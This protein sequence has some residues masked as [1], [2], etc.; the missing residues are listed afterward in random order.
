MSDSKREDVFDFDVTGMWRL[1]TDVQRLGFETA[2]SVARRFGRMV[3]EDLGPRWGVSRDKTSA[4]K[5]DAAVTSPEDRIGDTIQS[6]MEAYAELMQASWEAFNAVV[7]LTL[8]ISRP[9]VRGMSRDLVELETTAGGEAAEGS[10]YLHNTT[11]EVTGEVV[12][13]TDGL[14]GP[15]GATIPADAVKL[16]PPSIKS[17]PAGK[18]QEVKIEVEVG[19]V[20]PGRYVGQLQATTNPVTQ[21]DLA[22]VITAREE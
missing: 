1:F 12:V 5:D 10:F 14:I 22:I 4:D 16:K 20:T 11:Y 9:W 15:G 7:D 21:L 2:A 18:S 13:S 19:D 17:I 8:D 3:D 6:A